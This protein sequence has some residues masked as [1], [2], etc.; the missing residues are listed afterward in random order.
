MQAETKLLIACV[1]FSLG[2]MQFGLKHEPMILMLSRPVCLQLS[3]VKVC[4]LYSQ[5][6]RVRWRAAAHAVQCNMT[7]SP[8]PAAI[9]TALAVL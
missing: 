6:G 1:T 2:S 8:L 7:L 3:C 4:T 9:H 5:P